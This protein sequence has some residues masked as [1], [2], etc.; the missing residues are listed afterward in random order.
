MR[1]PSGPGSVASRTEAGYMDAVTFTPCGHSST[2]RVGA[3]HTWRLP[4]RRLAEHLA[5]PALVSRRGGRAA[6]PIPASPFSVP[7][8]ASDMRENSLGRAASLPISGGFILRKR[9][10][11]Q[12]NSPRLLFINRLF[13]LRQTVILSIP[14]R[15]KPEQARSLILRKRDISGRDPAYLLFIICLFISRQMRSPRAS[16]FV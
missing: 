6:N 16:A 9:L 4:S 15:Q 11:S 13:I 1:I 12:L 7:G 10:I 14:G 8:Q 2:C 3:D 5:D